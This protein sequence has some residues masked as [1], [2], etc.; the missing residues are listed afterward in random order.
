M[1]KIQSRDFS[2]YFLDLCTF[3]MLITSSPIKTIA[4]ENEDSRC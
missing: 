3:I 4:I 2:E 1:G